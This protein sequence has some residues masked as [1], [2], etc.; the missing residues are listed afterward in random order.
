LLKGFARVSLQ[1]GESKIV[2]FKINQSHLA[3]YDVNNK[4][5]VAE[6]GLFKI[7]IGASSRDIRMVADLQLD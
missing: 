1:P 3:F 2:S 6:P 5:W 4:K 7:M